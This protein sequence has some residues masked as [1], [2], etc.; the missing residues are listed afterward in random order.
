MFVQIIEA[1]AKDADAVRKQFDRWEE[2]LRAGATGFLGSTGGISDDGRLVMMARFE[3]ADAAKR[4]SDRAEQ[5]T[6]W[7]E[8][9]QYLESP[10]F[11]DSEDVETFLGGGSNDAGFIQVIQ[12]RATDKAKVQAMNKQFESEMRE[13]RPDLIGSVTVWDGDRFTDF[14]YFTSEEEARKGEAQASDAPEFQ[15]WQSLMADVTF[16]DLRSPMLS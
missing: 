7:E 16:T 8:T 14:A 10:K 6:W 15:E 9:S 13:R 2:A 5:G 12:G 1:R 3:S 4:N 11:T